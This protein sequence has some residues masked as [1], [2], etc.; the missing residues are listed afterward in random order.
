MKRIPPFLQAAPR[1]RRSI[2]LLSLALASLLSLHPSL[3]QT[4]AQ[5]TKPK[6]TPT[7]TPP[8]TPATSPAA[9]RSLE[10][11]GGAPSS[12]NP[13]TEP[14]AIRD[15]WFER[16]GQSHALIIGISK[17]P[18]LRPELQ[19]AYPAADARA[20]YEF[21]TSRNGGFL[22][23]NVTLLTDEQATQ[24]QILNSLDKLRDVL[25]ESLVLIFFAGHGEVL[26][27]KQGGADQGFLLPYDARADSLAG[28]AVQMDQFNNT[29]KKIRAR[30]TIIITDACKSGTIGDLG[31]QRL[32]GIAAKDIDETD[33]NDYQS[34]FILTAAG[35]AQSSL[36]FP[37]LKHGVFTYYLLEALS[38][39]ADGDGNGLVTAGEA[40]QY[41]RANVSQQV[42]KRTRGEYSQEPET[43][44]RYDA[45]IP[46]AVMSDSGL[47]ETRNW[48]ESD[49]FVLLTAA[50]FDGA[51][52]EKKLTEP[53]RLNAYYYYTRLKD[54]PRTPEKLIT[55][56][57]E[58][59]QAKLKGLS[60][61]ILQLA[62]EKSS[63]WI[64][65]ADWL[66]KAHELAIEKDPSLPVWRYFAKGMKFHYEESPGR[67]AREFAN[68]LTELE[69]S[70]FRDDLSALI[71]ARIGRVCKKLD[72]SEEALRAYALATAERPQVEWRC[73]Y[74]ELLA[75][76]RR[77]A[78]AEKQLRAA[79]REDPNHM[80]AFKQLAALLLDG[81]SAPA[82]EKLPERY[83]EA[84]GAAQRAHKLSNGAIETEEVLGLALLENRRTGEAI[85]SLG[86]VARHFLA[87][88]AQRDRALWQLSEA[89]LRPG[90]VDRSLS[91]LDE[92]ARRGSHSAQIHGQLA[93][94]LARQG[95]F[96][97]AI[98]ATRKA[99]EFANESKQEKAQ[100]CRQ[101]GDYYERTGRLQDAKIVYRDAADAAAGDN[102]L[103]QELER[104]AQVLGLR[105][106]E[107][108]DAT[109]KPA[110]AAAA[111]QLYGQLT[112]P[113]G[114]A[115]LERL[116]G[117]RI[118]E[119]NQTE[120]LALI[121]DACLYDQET[122][123][124]LIAY[125]DLY[126]EFIHQAERK[127]FTSGQLNF[128]AAG[129]SDEKT[130]DLLRFFGLQDKNGR[131]ETSN[132]NDFKKRQVLLQALGADAQACA[133]GE[134]VQLR[135]KNDR[136]PMLL[137]LEQWLIG[138]E[139]NKFR[140]AKNSRPD[141]IWLFFLR[142]DAR[143]KFYAGAS[144][145]PE[146]AVKPLLAALLTKENL[147][148]D[149]AFSQ[150]MYFAAPYL[151][152][153]AQ[154][155]LILPGGER[156]WQEA[157][158][159]MPNSTD[160]IPAF[161]RQENGGLLYLLAALSAAGAA[162]ERAAASAAF[163]PLSR[164]LQ[165]AQLPAARDPF[166]LI[167]L[168]SHLRADGESSL[169]LPRAVE[170]WLGVAKGGDALAPL[171]AKAGAVA[172][173]KP[174][175]IARQAAALAQVGRE[176]PEWADNAKAL[177]LVARQIAADREA[178][179][180][181]ALDLRMSAP[182]LE[183]WFNRVATLEAPPST[184]EKNNR[185]AARSAEL[186]AERIRLVRV[187]Q[188]AF[189]LAR[190]LRLRGALTGEQT[191][192]LVDKL[193]AL[194]PDGDRYVFAVFDLLKSALPAG[195]LEETL[196]AALARSPRMIWPPAMATGKEPG[197]SVAQIDA[198]AERLAQIKR[199]SATQKHA[200]LGA[201]AEAIAALDALAANGADAAALKR[202]QSALD[203]FALEPAPVDPRQKKSKEKTPAPPSLK[204][205]VNGLAAPAAASSLA[206]VRR[207]IAPFI[208]EALLGAVYAAHG[209]AAIDF[210][211]AAPNLVRH[212][213]PSVSRWSQTEFD[214]AKKTMRGSVARVNAAL[215]AEAARAAQ[216]GSNGLLHESLAAAL[217]AAQQLQ[218]QSVA[219]P[220]AARL[221]A[222]A[223]DLGEDLIARAALGDAQA[224]AL[225]K[226]HLPRLLT[227]RRAAQFLAAH[228]QGGALPLTSSELFALGQI[229]FENRVKERSLDELTR[230]FGAMGELAALARELAPAS[231]GDVA[232]A[233]QMAWRNFGMP[234][235][236]QTGL[237]R[238]ALAPFEPYEQARSFQSTERLAERMQD[239]KLNLARLA[240][241]TG[242]ADA[243]P[244]QTGLL[245]SILRDADARVR[246]ATNGA[247][248]TPLAD[249]D[250]QTVESLLQTTA[251]EKTVQAFLTRL[252]QSPGRQQQPLPA[253][254]Q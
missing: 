197:L 66:D 145:L 166:D 147:E 93:R 10:T 23:E 213:D 234:V 110:E 254:N 71:A 219:A 88:N 31:S 105:A 103:K 238:L 42:A 59:L 160:L 186:Q 251:L 37:E 109:R 39:K 180:D 142:N 96:T 55:Q 129:A 33:A 49:P 63:D 170:T 182:Q 29:I 135:W 239:L 121:F 202:L 79:S 157:F 95:A 173:G 16:G 52:R 68:A 242:A 69:D 27:S 232:Q 47:A 221:V 191:A 159:K 124:R 106:G 99:L 18:N 53:A 101:L 125:F 134:A 40:Y 14:V 32:R 86:K 152:V 130:R 192:A 205:L 12:T 144:Q 72:R 4:N 253:W 92:A 237:Q 28:T 44:A 175:L 116:T 143:M 161:F 195:P 108:R 117:V 196:L 164:A 179:V 57:R 73:E 172:P 249:R 203:R 48:F 136:L 215:A 78:E 41:V 204:E 167:D 76:A 187:D 224:D 74:A 3:F 217:L 65:A 241:R 233:V 181:T 24:E 81:A 60:R 194:S 228:E 229:E 220:R 212:H 89:F 126:P 158:A 107:K 207:Q 176:R 132:Q 193:L 61:T 104:R 67:A 174:L 82:A 113:G 151:R 246:S 13:T 56:K 156:A 208:G 100:L 118:N 149:E 19:L 90:D 206:E 54:N 15:P 94:L 210:L 146:T 185:N 123:N 252:E 150:A 75:R 209:D 36:E 51:L 43:N 168:F 243:L 198:S 201:V 131:R 236:N 153:S 218:D 154:G 87:D 2:G 199:A 248:G 38:G 1:T 91:A 22:P 177:D 189:E 223:L 26:R 222:A 214:A 21:L 250:W 139:A 127:G 119:K 165:K 30:S 216:A 245:L 183:R 227:P 133:R 85:Q 46:F 184:P 200:H 77:F 6:P 169:R 97:L 188:S 122:R 98:D 111:A 141:E 20:L 9:R 148:N 34:T 162:G 114:L 211:Q 64:N 240:V 50:N 247:N 84:L 11:K 17:Y 230:E 138:K 102:R 35:P 128:P 25:K 70:R 45:S 155:Q 231:N 120:A 5:Q 225:L 7:P 226:E 8:Q 244:L 58:E 235:T 83:A 190:L 140:E 171:L 115:A 137:G 163:K 112:V 80:P 178:I 62:P